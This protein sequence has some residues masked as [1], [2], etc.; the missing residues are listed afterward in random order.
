MDSVSTSVLMLQSDPDTVPVAVTLPVTVRF[1]PMFMALAKSYTDGV[2][3]TLTFRISTWPVD[4]V[5][6]VLR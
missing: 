2:V 4:C 3:M 1:P 5:M 6:A